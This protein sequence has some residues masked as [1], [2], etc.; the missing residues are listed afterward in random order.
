MLKSLKLLGIIIGLSFAV[1]TFALTLNGIATYEL[2]R[3][4][5]YIASLF[6][7]NPS[8][9]PEIIMASSQSKR[10]AIRVTSRRW[11]SG[12]WFNMWQNDIAINNPFVDDDEL[13]DQLMVFSKFLEAP[14]VKGDEII[15]DYIMGVGTSISINNIQIMSSSNDRLFSLLVNAW[16]GKFPPS[17]E[18]KRRILSAQKDELSQ[19]LNARYKSVNYTNQRSQLIASWIQQRKDDELAERNAKAKVRADAKAATLAK[20]KALAD[21]KAA[22]LAKVAK[23][24]ALAEMDREAK[25]LRK[26]K[27]EAV[28]KSEIKPVKA[29]VAAKKVVKENKPKKTASAVVSSKT[30]SKKQRAT[31]NRYYLAL[32][33]WK[34]KSDIRKAITYPEWALEFGKAGTVNVSFSVNRKGVVSK[35]INL[36]ESV[37]EL[38]SSEVQNTIKGLVPLMSPP[39]ELLGSDWTVLFSYKFDP[40]NNSQVT[41]KKPVLPDF[42]SKSSQLTRAEYIKRLNQYSDE[43]K[44]II[45][46]KIEYPG[47]AKKL[48]NKGLVEVEIKVSNEGL[49]LE[50]KDI[51][52]TPHRTLNQE[53]RDA[54]RRSQPLPRIPVELKLNSAKVIIKYNFK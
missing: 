45:G 9:N 40:K 7:T 18:F 22:A 19:E 46:S 41:L 3:K 1:N 15:I 31:Q 21:A 51:N 17:G 54:I 13:I 30:L 49:V 8:D 32:Y 4:E 5:I 52:M 11:S 53:V 25:A 10:M 36:D 20:A 43:V 28:V 12:R 27:F 35:L 23:Q 2:L 6:L 29:Y 16:I 44:R 39:D 42:L 33:E 50:S 24:K 34:L 47:W 26:K 48:N 37:S 38:L 14:L